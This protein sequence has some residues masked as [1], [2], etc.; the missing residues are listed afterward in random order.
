M[1][2]NK[3]TAVMLCTRWHHISALQRTFI[4]VTSE[5]CFFGV[6]IAVAHS[7]L[8]FTTSSKPKA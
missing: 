8:T 1:V 2:K 7:V 6:K 4:H 5:T 3:I